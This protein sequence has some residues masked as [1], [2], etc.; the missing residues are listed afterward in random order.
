MDK[1]VESDTCYTCQKKFKEQDESF[2]C[3]VCMTAYHLKCVGVTKKEL[4]AR[5]DGKFLR[6]YCD[7]CMAQKNE[8]EDQIKLLL[9]YVYKLDLHNQTQIQK[10]AQDSAMINS[11]LAKLENIETKVSSLAENKT[12]VNSQLHTYAGVVGNT[13][14]PVVVIKPKQKQNS[15]KTLEEISNNVD[16]SELKICN[17]RNAKDGSVVLCCKN[18][19]DTMKVKQVVNDRLGDGYEVVLPDIKKPR[20]RITN[21]D[22]NIADENIINELKKNNKQIEETDMAMVTVMKKSKRSTTYKEVIVEVKSDGYKKMMEMG[23]LQLPWRECG[24]FEHLF[25]KRCYKCCGF[26]HISKDCKHNQ[27]CSKCSGPHK[28]SEC[29][30]K[31]VCCVNCKMANERF[32]MNLQTRHHAWSKECSVL[33]RRMNALRNKIEY[34]T[35]E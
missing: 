28:Y 8:S 9:K 13:V 25:L 31:N 21:I 24:V 33:Q 5:C 15:S 20:L 22:S 23:K 18:A 34:N 4:K 16:K 3:D 2:E 29:K 7:Y 32:G 27:K 1:K 30:T 17:T 35:S 6:L 14:Q 19:V 11:I 26:Y 10:N 12:S